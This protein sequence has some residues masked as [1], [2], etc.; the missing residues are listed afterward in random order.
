VSDPSFV[1]ARSVVP[2]T[3]VRRCRV[4]GE[5]ITTEWGPETFEQSE[6][7]LREH[8]DHHSFSD[9]YAWAFREHCGS[10]GTR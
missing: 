1:G 4:C 7:D 2:T 9:F 8:L 5:A 3:F 6:R 10:G